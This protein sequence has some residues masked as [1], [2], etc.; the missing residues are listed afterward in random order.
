MILS[1][2]A[3]TVVAIGVAWTSAHAAPSVG[4]LADAMLQQIGRTSAATLGSGPR[5]VDVFFDPNCP[6]CHELYDDLQRLAGGDPD[7]LALRLAPAT[8]LLEA[9]WAVVALREL[10]AAT[11]PDTDAVAQAVRA[12][13]QAAWAWREGF[14][15]RCIALDAAGVRWIGALRDAPTLGAALERAGDDVDVAAWLGDAVRSGWIDGID[16]VTTQETLT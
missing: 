4:Q 6:Y 1:T 15:A 16:A 7:A 13:P 10:H 2:L 14:D 11:E 8:R 12:A 5:V 9:D 3:A